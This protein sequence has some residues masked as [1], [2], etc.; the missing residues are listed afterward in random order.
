MLFNIKGGKDLSIGQVHEVADIIKNS[1]GTHAQVIFGV[2]QDKKWKKRARIT[3]VG[4]GVTSQKRQESKSLAT[5][6]NQVFIHPQLPKYI[7]SHQANGLI[8]INSI[9]NQK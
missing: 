2:V 5:S 9:D 4:T 8:P 6:L 3:L 7:G 1:S